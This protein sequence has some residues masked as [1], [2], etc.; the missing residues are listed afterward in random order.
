MRRFLVLPLALMLAGSIAF[1]ACGDD[2]D[3]DEPSAASTTAPEATDDSAVAAN[4]VAALAVI[5]GAGLHSIDETLNAEGG[6]IDPQWLGRVDHARIA[7]A[8]V[9][10]PEALQQRADDVVAALG[11]LL[12]ALD[13]D[14]AAGAAEPAA[15]AHQAWHGFSEVGWRTVAEMAG[16]SPVG[17]E[18]D[19]ASDEQEHDAG[20]T[21]TAAADEAEGEGH[22]DMDTEE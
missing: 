2:D 19:A 12:V 18:H 9:D 10:W 1:A 13:A 3:D 4:L 7:V 11:V 5:D 8:A 14:D 21:A 16:V 15:L 22:D 17:G 20:A 6:V